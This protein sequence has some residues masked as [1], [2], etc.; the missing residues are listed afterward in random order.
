MSAQGRRE[1]PLLFAGD[2]CL[3][4]LAL[5]TTLF[6]R[7]GSI[8]SSKIFLQHLV[9]FAFLFLIS[10]LVFFIAGLYEKHTLLFKSNLLETIFYAQV[11]NIIVAALFFFLVPAFGIQPKTNLFIYLLLSTAFISLW[12][13]YLF[14]LFAIRT[15]ETALLIGGEEPDCQA[16]YDEINGNNRYGIKFVGGGPIS[17]SDKAKISHDILAHVENNEVS[18]VVLPFALFDDPTFLSEW[19]KM[20]FKGVRFID[21]ALLFEDLFDRVSLPLLSRQWFLDESA[22]KERS[23]YVFSKR[24]IDILIATS[25]LIILSPFMLLI[26][27]ILIMGEGGTAFIF[28][29]RIGKGGQPIQ[30]IKFRTMLFDDGGDPDKQSANRMTVFG[31][32]LRQTQ[33]DELPQFWNVLRG[34]L[35]LIGPRPEVPALTK[36]YE[37]LI[38]FYNTRHMIEPGISGWAQ[39]KHASPPKFKL[40]ADATRQK[41]SYDLYYLKHRSLILDVAIILQTIKIVV[42]RASK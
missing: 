29:T 33:M 17:Y 32:F 41:L 9:P 27:L 13:I 25:A 39:I 42:A 24:L 38:P 2:I 28:Q 18:V 20:V 35:S 16:V 34:D 4:V 10:T 15:R 31:K 3:L 30:I 40:D 21:A 8:P 23:L 37:K 11:A 26:V 19:G 36:E 22:K 14:P 6:V 12:R 1:A 5:W 7:Y